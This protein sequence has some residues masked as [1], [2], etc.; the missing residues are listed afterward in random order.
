MSQSRR[1]Y[2]TFCEQTFVSNDVEKCS[3]C[4]KTGGLIDPANP[5]AVADLVRKRK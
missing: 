2:C 1:V 4:Q 5:A 3:L